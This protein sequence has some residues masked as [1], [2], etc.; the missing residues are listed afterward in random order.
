MSKRKSA[1][2][3]G[4]ERWNAERQR[5]EIRI[6]VGTD[7]D[8]KPIRRMA[9]GKTQ[10]EAR[11]K[12]KALTATVEIDASAPVGITLSQWAA[13]WLSEILP[14]EDV[15]QTMR[16]NYA[17]RLRLYVLPYVGA[18]AL[19]DLRADHVRQMLAKLRDKGLSDGTLNDA[20]RSL[21]RL[22]NAAKTEGY[23]SVNHVEAVKT[24]PTNYKRGKALTMAEAK[25]LLSH[26]KGHPMEAHVMTLL[27]L[28]MR[29][30]EMLGLTWNDLD[31]D[32]LKLT[33]K[34]TL[35]HL[36][37]KGHEADFYV[38]EYR[39][40]TEKSIRPIPLSPALADAFRRHR[41]NQ[42]E[43]RLSFGAEWGN[44][45]P[46]HDFVFTRSD[47]KAMRFDTLRSQVRK[48]TDA[49]GLNKWNPYGMRHSAISLLAE[50]G[51]SSKMIS[52]L[53]GNSPRIAE[54]VYMHTVEQAKRDA[55]NDFAARIAH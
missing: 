24:P 22:M 36:K 1:N 5:W 27:T 8:G 45:F 4:S 41:I 43:A 55:V 30:G 20:Y 39:A 32:G 12:L 49:A 9:T 25:K 31:L 18:L 34:R 40:K 35:H 14:L 53:A 51:Y 19:I 6:T 2:G 29:P 13:K 33:V 10:A 7:D 23:V 11:T 47:G 44:D 54:E 16:K 37:N 15:S 52:E 3:M 26:I 46:D 38:T 48:V 50:L 21:N 42:L 17:E 28:G